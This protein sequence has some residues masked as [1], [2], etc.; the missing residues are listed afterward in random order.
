MEFERVY[1][2]FQKITNKNYVSSEN[3][4]PKEDILQAHWNRFYSIHINRHIA[5][6]LIDS[7]SRMFL[8]S[9]RY[10]VESKIFHRTI[11]TNFHYSTR[12]CPVNFMIWQAWWGN[13]K[14]DSTNVKL[15]I[16]QIIGEQNVST[17]ELQMNLLSY[18]KHQLCIFWRYLNQ[19]RKSAST[20]G[21][22]K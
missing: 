16:F 4:M 8:I 14:I 3:W 2:N 12:G 21:L 10:G 9:I 22:D 6:F 11:K 19:S 18:C 20:I 5:A 13:L 7:R 17:Y 1:V 15:N